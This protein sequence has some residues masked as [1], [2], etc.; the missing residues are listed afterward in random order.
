MDDPRA[1]DKIRDLIP[2]L[3]TDDCHVEEIDSGIRITFYDGQ[4]FDIFEVGGWVQV[5]TVIFDDE[6]LEKYDYKEELTEFVLTLNSRCL[7][8]R[9]A[10]EPDG[11]LLLVEDIQLEK[12]DADTINNAID[13]I[14]FVDY[15][16]YEM[17]VE[18]GRLGV[19]P[20]EDEIDAVVNEKEGVYDRYH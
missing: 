3:K 13:A 16:F 6:E 17:I 9:F 5:G 10:L 1:A 4:V 12:I 18:T 20:S 2:A 19:P 15:V 8:C 14:S 11:S 7:G